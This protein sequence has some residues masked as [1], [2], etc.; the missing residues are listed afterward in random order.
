MRRYPTVS[1]YARVS[2]TRRNRQKRGL[3]VMDGNSPEAH[4]LRRVQRKLLEHLGGE[5][6]APQRALV[7]KIAWIELRCLLLDKKLLESRET[8]YDHDVYLAHANAAARM[9]KLLGI[10]PP[11]PDFASLMRGPGSPRREAA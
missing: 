2:P 11:K 5:P 8:P 10:E 6:T 9:Y 4:F 7:N 1:P 3:V